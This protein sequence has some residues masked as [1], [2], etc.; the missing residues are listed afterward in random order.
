MGRKWYIVILLLVALSTIAV[1]VISKHADEFATAMGCTDHTLSAADSPDGRYVAFVFRRECGATAPDSTQANVQP[2]G[3]ALDSEKY[4]AFVV[5]DGAPRLNLRWDNTNR[6]A[7][8]GI[9][10]ERIYRQ[11]S[12]VDGIG[13]RYEA[14]KR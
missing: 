11:E 5:V 2:I 13:I 7:V 9:T 6:L 8:G 3:T 4:K 12:A 14:D 10:T 1:W